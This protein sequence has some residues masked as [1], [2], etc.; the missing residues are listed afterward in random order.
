MAYGAVNSNKDNKID[1]STNSQREEKD[2]HF[3]FARNKHNK[4]S[5]PVGLGFDQ[6]AIGIEGKRLISKW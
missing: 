1:K 2:G 6:L 3:M 5:S 4:I